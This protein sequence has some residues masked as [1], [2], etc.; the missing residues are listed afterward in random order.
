MVSGLHV[1]AWVSLYKSCHSFVMGDAIMRGWP[2]GGTVL[3]Q[4][5]VT[6]TMFDVIAEEIGKEQ[7]Q[8]AKRAHDSRK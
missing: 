2:D 4:P 1:S 5:A 7:E 8:E 6:V 3:E